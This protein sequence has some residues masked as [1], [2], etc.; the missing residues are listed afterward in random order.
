MP[1][2]ARRQWW[3]CQV[4][5]VVVGW[6]S[7]FLD[8]WSGRQGDA[9]AGVLVHPEQRGRGIGSALWDLARAHLADIGATRVVAYSRGEDASR[10]FCEQRGLRLTSS[11]EVLALDPR[12]LQAPPSPPQGVVVRPC[13]AYRD[14]LERL[15]RVDYEAS[16]DE[17]GEL[18][19]SAVTYE[20]WL[21]MTFE[22][23]DFDAELSVAV[24]VRDEPAGISL[25]VTDRASGRA[26]SIGTSVLREHRG[27]GLATLMK[28]HSLAAAGA[29]GIGRAV[30]QNDETNAP[31]LA[32]NRTLGYVPFATRFGWTLDR[33]A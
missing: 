30:T 33:V 11:I 5:G 13:A 20:E 19:F 1:A 4:D 15:Y 7:A 29:A 3:T 16:Q 2:R 17:P 31:M 10:Q 9:A 14:D 27:S 26:A 28:R 32:I 8:T 23:P 21:A 25:L 24:E 18:D 12:S 22:H 6:A